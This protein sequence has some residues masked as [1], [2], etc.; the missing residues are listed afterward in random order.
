MNPESLWDV[1]VIDAAIPTMNRN[2]AVEDVDWDF[3]GGDP[4]P[5][6]TGLSDSGDNVVTGEIDPRD[7]VLMPASLG[8][9]DQDGRAVVE[10]ILPPTIG[11]GLMGV[12]AHHAY[13][14]F[15][16]ASQLTFASNAATLRF[17]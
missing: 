4:D 2:A 14:T 3:F 15:N 10:F 8:T 11:A 7:N 1:T 5:Y 13:V 16:S 9:L 6:I 12:E 17:S